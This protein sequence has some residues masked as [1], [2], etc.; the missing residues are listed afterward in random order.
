MVISRILLF[1][2]LGPVRDVS[3]AFVIRRSGALWRISELLSQLIF[4]MRSGMFFFDCY[5]GYVVLARSWLKWYELNNIVNLKSCN[6][7]FC[8]VRGPCPVWMAQIINIR[9]YYCYYLVKFASIV[10]IRESP[11]SQRTVLAWSH[12]PELLVSRIAT[13]IVLIWY[14]IVFFSNI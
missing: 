4:S 9:H 2:F 10:N 3:V 5:S 13:I 7:F 14:Y 11:G 8:F 12:G 1:G 6:V